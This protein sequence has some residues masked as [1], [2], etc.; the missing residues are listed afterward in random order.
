MFAVKHECVFTGRK[1]REKAAAAAA[2]AVWP[3]SFS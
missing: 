1:Q 2:A 3:V